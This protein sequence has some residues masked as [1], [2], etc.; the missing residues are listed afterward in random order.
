[1]LAQP[2]GGRAAARVREQALCADLRVR[3]SAPLLSPIYAFVVTQPSVGIS[4]HLTTSRWREGAMTDNHRDTLVVDHHLAADPT[5]ASL[6]WMMEDSRRLTLEA[7]AGLDLATLD[8][9]PEIGGNSIGALLY[10]IAAVEA[11]WLY[12]EVLGEEPPA[13]VHALFP[14]DM[15]DESGHLTRWRGDDLPTLEHRLAEIRQQLLATYTSM[16]AEDFHR[17]RALP[18]YDVTPEWVLHHLLQDEAVHRGEM[19]MVKLLAEQSRI[20]S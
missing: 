7:V 11:D 15:S 18:D 14:Q 8:W 2:E 4:H 13:A 20:R 6:L 12:A 9:E 3:R 10:H 19:G 17:P 16:A 1:M 5:I